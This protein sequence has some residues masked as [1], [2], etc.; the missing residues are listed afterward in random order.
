MNGRPTAMLKISRKEF[1]EWY[2]IHKKL[3][4]KREKKA[5]TKGRNH[6]SIIK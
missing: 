5:Q 6:A 3:A 4:E 1:E 2:T